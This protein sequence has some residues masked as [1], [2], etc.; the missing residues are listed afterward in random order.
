VLKQIQ[1]ISN[2][3]KDMFYIHAGIKYREY[4]IPA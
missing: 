3:E 2:I 4:L 1:D